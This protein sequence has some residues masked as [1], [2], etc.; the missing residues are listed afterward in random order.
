MHC[1][2]RSARIQFPHYRARFELK[3]V[4]GFPGTNKI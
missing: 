2:S 4:S 3:G 1:V